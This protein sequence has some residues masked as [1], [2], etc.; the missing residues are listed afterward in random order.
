[1]L[2]G[3]VL[4][5]LLKFVHGMWRVGDWTEVHA[6]L[7]GI[8]HTHTHGTL[9]SSLLNTHF[10][11]SHVHTHIHT[12]HTTQQAK[13]TTPADSE[14]QIKKSLSRQHAKDIS[15]YTKQIHTRDKEIEKLKQK[16]AKASL[17]QALQVL[18]L[19][20]S[21]IACP[22]DTNVLDG[23]LM[24]LGGLANGRLANLLGAG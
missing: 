23:W 12:T 2:C 16:L 24:Y 5:L 13:V 19:G 7:L 3:C 8:P 22:R 20:T 21:T 1:M 11:L 10:H 17:R 9:I 15:E 18:F 14:Q 6:F 4:V